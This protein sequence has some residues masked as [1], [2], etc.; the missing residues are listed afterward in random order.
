MVLDLIGTPFLGTHRIAR[1]VW[2]IIVIVTSGALMRYIQE[3]L[4]KDDQRKE[5]KE[6][7]HRKRKE[8]VGQDFHTGSAQNRKKGSA[9]QRIH[10]ILKCMVIHTDP[11]IKYDNA[12]H[13]YWKNL[14]RKTE[15]FPKGF[16]AVHLLLRSSKI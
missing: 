3:R 11:Y 13:D 2:H 8:H 4:V 10:C 5:E 14:G 9:N 6:K 15:P 1:C 7:D 16:G 12:G